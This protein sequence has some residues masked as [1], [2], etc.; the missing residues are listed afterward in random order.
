[1]KASAII[2]ELNPLHNGHKYIMDKAKEDSNP[3]VMVMS[4]NFVQ[5]G[6]PA[7]VDKWTRAK[8][9]LSEGADLVIELP[10][11][12][13]CSSAEY[14]A[15]GA[16]SILKATKLEYNLLFGIEGDNRGAL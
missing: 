15:K 7:C 13:S 9:A 3:L 14:F 11:I 1:M 6:C 8:A 10:D 12:Y 2:C 16:I 4:G 5:R